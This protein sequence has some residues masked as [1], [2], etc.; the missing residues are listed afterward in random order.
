MSWVIFALTVFIFD[1]ALQEAYTRCLEALTSSTE[2]HEVP[3][4]VSF[5]LSFSFR[6]KI[7]SKIFRLTR[8]GLGWKMGAEVGGPLYIAGPL[9]LLA[10]ELPRTLI[11]ILILIFVF[12]DTALSW[13]FKWQL[14]FIKN[15]FNWLCSSKNTRLVCEVFQEIR[16]LSVCQRAVFLL[17]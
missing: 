1:Q 8:E 3:V 2:P 13:V 5:T 14:Y 15:L 4:Q 16:W 12:P 17:H 7:I 11:L 9:R 6:G 10:N